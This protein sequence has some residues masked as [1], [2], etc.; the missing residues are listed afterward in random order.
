MIRGV[1][2]N[3]SEN[4]NKSVVGHCREHIHDIHATLQ[5]ELP[6]HESQ[7]FKFVVVHLPIL[8]WH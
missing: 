5:F 2:E 8:S 7:D 1:D 3:E 6:L 4:D